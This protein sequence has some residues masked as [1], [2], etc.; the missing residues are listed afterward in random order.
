MPTALREAGWAVET[1][2]DH[3][4][5]DMKDPELLP[6]V[7]ARGWVFLTQDWH[8]R[9]RA[10]EARAW[11]EAELKV[12]VLATG[13]LTA[14]ETVEILEK[15]R[16]RI[17]RTAARQDAPFVYRVAKDGSLRQVG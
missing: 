3:F 16:T 7:A 9:Y 14:E 13:S 8:I 10:A 17:E 12:I 5:Q 11:R 6:A 4:P 2:D 15:A 1:H